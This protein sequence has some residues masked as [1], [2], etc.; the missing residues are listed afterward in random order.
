VAEVASLMRVRAQAKGLPL[1]LEFEREIPEVIQTDPTRLRQ[2]LVNVL[3]NAIKFTET[4]EVRLITRLVR[5]AGE[6][7][8]EFDVVDTGIGMSAEQVAR[9]FQP[10]T[11][12]DA[13]T[14]RQ[15]GGTGL[16]LAISKRLAEL[17]SGNIAVVK[18]QPGVGTRFR[19]A[20]AT[21][22]L[23]GVRMIEDPA[24]AATIIR[25]AQTQTASVSASPLNGCRILLAE[26]G[27]DNQRLISHL[28]KRAGAWVAVVENGQLAVEAALAAQGEGRPF[29]VILMD[30]QM[31]V[32]DG[33]T[34]TSRLRE[35]GYKLPIVALTAH[36][37]QGDRAQCLKAGCDD[38]ATKP[39]ER[40]KLIEALL[41]Q[42]HEGHALLARARQPVA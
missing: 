29:D 36:A 9:L 25:E 5:A 19:I 27:P 16:G 8:L 39:I 6:P 26:D 12:A 13:S 37:M 32:L 4:G 10:F 17:L 18:T 20:V 34:A 42:V 40:G 30:M 3:A 21:G 22:P 11:Q 38:Y 7:Q 14:T 2:I 28:L 31:P 41:R 24:S 23:E 15:F 35:L 1:A 33:Y